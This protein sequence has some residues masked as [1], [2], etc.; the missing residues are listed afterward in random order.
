MTN[1]NAD[2]GAE[3]S[4]LQQIQAIDLHISELNSERRALERLLL[5]VRR[6]DLTVKDVSRKNSVDRIII[7]NSILERLKSSK[8]PVSARNLLKAAKK[9]SPELKDGTFRSYLTRM[10]DREL[11]TRSL[12]HGYWGLPKTGGKAGIS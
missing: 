8:N 7:E 12:T 9:V 4:I 3:Q 11:I 5:K 2:N 1:L 10:A 6:T